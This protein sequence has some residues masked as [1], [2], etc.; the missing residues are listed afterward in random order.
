MHATEIGFAFDL[1]RALV[2]IIT[3]P[4]LLMVSF[5]PAITKGIQKIQDQSSGMARPVKSSHAGDNF[6]IRKS[7]GKSK[8]LASSSAMDLKKIT[9]SN[10]E[11]A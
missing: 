11:P 4:L 1:V 8:V 10:V 9:T 7:V 2:Y 5:G 6:W 3:V